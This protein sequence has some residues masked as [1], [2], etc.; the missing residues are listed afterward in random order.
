ML[1]F[2][3]KTLPSAGSVR[4]SANAAIASARAYDHYH[5]DGDVDENDDEMMKIKHF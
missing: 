4:F 5:V 1:K 2:N 3:S